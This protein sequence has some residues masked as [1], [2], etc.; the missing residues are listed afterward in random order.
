MATLKQ[1][2]SQLSQYLPE[3]IR[4]E[5]LR[6]WNLLT[7]GDVNAFLWDIDKRYMN[8]TFRNN[9][10]YDPTNTLATGQHHCPICGE[11]VISGVPHPVYS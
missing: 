5:L 6:E 7:G 2:E 4:D 9:C 8:E 10:P 3:D 1:I 11:M